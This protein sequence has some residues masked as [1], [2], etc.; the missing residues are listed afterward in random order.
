LLGLYIDKVD[1]KVGS[2][3]LIFWENFRAF[4]CVVDRPKWM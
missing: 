3:Y 1:S 2:Q 4:K